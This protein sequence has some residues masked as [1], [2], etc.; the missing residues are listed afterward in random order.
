M[1][2]YTITGSIEAD[3]YELSGGGGLV[4][5]S[6][7][8][9]NNFL[10]RGN[11]G[12]DV[13]IA[14][15]DDVHGTFFE[16]D[17]EV[18]NMRPSTDQLA[19]IN[20]QES[21]AGVDTARM[22]FDDSNDRLTL[23]SQGD[24]HLTSFAG[25]TL[26][27]N[28]DL[29]MLLGVS[30]AARFDRANGTDADPLVEFDTA[31]NTNGGFMC[32]IVGGRDPVANSVTALDNTLYSREG[33]ANSDL[34]LNISPTIAATDDWISLR[35]NSTIT[36]GGK[37]M[38]T[39]P[40]TNYLLP[41]NQ[42][43]SAQTSVKQVPI[44]RGGF[45]K[46]FSMRHTTAPGNSNLVVYTVQVNAVDTAITV[47]IAADST[48]KVTDSTNGVFVVEGDLISVKVTKALAIGNTPTDIFGNLG[49]S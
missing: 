29:T 13:D 18:I 25:L 4:N 12:T 37:D 34:L 20:F 46:G 6:D 31:E 11:G 40:T 33:F 49:V 9:T 16:D 45:L 44:Q 23:F 32:L 39:S 17:G 8:L 10:V 24:V 19:G 27:S 1:A 28:T 22:T 21:S 5:T 41:G 38:N 30:A 48:T 36:W 43:R 2:D 15:S 35:E 3:S 42:N 47:S 7:T 26:N 14:T